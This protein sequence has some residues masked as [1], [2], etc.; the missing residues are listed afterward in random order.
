M[1]NIHAV[2][3]NGLFRPTGPVELPDHC[4]VEFVPRIIRQ[5]DDAQHVE[6]VTEILERRANSEQSDIAERHNEHQP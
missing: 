5:S 3:E 2:Y 6:R 4:E 1:K